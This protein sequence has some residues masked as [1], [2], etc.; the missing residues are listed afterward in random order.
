MSS[1]TH[2]RGKKPKTHTHE[3]KGRMNGKE[4]IMVV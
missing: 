4:R 1:G 3:V 2:F